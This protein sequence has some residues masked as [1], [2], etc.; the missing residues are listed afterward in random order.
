MLPPAYRERY[1]AFLE[2]LQQLQESLTED[3]DPQQLKPI[4]S[5]LQAQ[6]QGEIMSLT[7]EALSGETLSSWQSS[8][9][10]VHRMMRLLQNDMMFLQTSRRLQTSQQ[11]LT[12][13]R[14]RVGKLIDFAD[15]LTKE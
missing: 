5:Q 12:T 7:G 4:F 1:Q 10:E 6:F 13:V 3:V 14:D 15:A 8:Q 9:T 2:T 11:R